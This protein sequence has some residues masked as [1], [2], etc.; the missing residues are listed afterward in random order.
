MK[1]TILRTTTWQSGK[2]KAVEVI[3]RAVVSVDSDGGDEQVEDR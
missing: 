1:P 2:G 3:K